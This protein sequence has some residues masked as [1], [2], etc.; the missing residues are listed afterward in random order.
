MRI[1]VCGAA[2]GYLAVLLLGTWGCGREPALPNDPFDNVVL[3]TIDTLRADHLGSYGY[4]RPVSPFLDSLAAEGV[5]FD[6]AVSSASHTGPAHA[7]LFT[8][9]YPS[10]HG[11]VTNGVKLGG[12]GPTLA[13]ALSGSG[14]QTAAVTSVSFLKGVA[15][16]FE[17]KRGK[18]TA[19]GH[20]PADQTVADAIDWLDNIGAEDRFFLWVHLYDVHSS[21]DGLMPP[22]EYLQRMRLDSEQRGRGLQNFLQ[23]QHGTP[24]SMIEEDFDRFNRYD[25]QIAF[26]DDQLRRLFEEVESRFA[27]SK[28]LWV[29]TADHGEGLGNHDFTYHGKHLYTEQ[30]RV[31]LI[32]FGGDDW[33]GGGE[34]DHL[35]RHVDLFPT[36]AD[37]V[38][39]STDQLVVDPEG[40]SLRPL[41]E[42]PS[43][44]L[45]IEH[46]VSQR[47]PAGS[48]QLR[49]GW[50]NEI[51]LSVQ[52]E[53]YKYIL[54]SESPDELYD[55]ESDP[56][57]RVN[58]AGQGL[59]AER[60]LGTWLAKKYSWMQDNRLF[61]RARGFRVE[62]EFVDE[63]RALGYLD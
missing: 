30:L 56:H 48:K 21:G 32:F 44:T 18:G 16:G 1:G 28:T 47:R 27:D 34:V 33:T 12:G 42:D 40:I 26:V 29:V 63:L 41:L 20:R 8:S 31:P 11:V 61:D 35:V 25:A 7:S 17:H 53:R 14:F 2:I 6:R 52:T 38:G 4:P 45:P 55:L 24:V 5:R 43:A 22:E 37:L 10:R 13:E 3:I 54:H 19:E 39:V 58:L 9:Q 49:E 57:E 36:I 23:Q 59:P 46:A 50:K 60:E 51:V 15:R 62:E